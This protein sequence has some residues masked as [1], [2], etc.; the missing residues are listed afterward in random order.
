M[1][2]HGKGNDICH[3]CLFAHKKPGR[4]SNKVAVWVLEHTQPKWWHGKD[5]ENS[6]LELQAIN[7]EVAHLKMKSWPRLMKNLLQA[8]RN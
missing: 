5:E 6:L 1:L 7:R 2:I 8:M 3:L 4:E